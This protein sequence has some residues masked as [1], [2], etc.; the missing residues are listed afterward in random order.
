[1]DDAQVYQKFRPNYL[2][3]VNIPQW[4][5]IYT[6]KHLALMIILISERRDNSIKITTDNEG[7]GQMIQGLNSQESLTILGMY[8]PK[9]KVL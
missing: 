9:N 7:C 3:S 4:L 2:L 5:W 8:T 1:M 6:L